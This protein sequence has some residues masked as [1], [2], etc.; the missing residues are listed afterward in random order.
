MN[1]KT[2]LGTELKYKVTMTA[3]GFDMDTDDWEVTIVRGATKRTFTKSECVQGQDGWF[4]CFDTKDFGA[5]NYYAIMTAFVPDADFDDG[6]R[7]EVKKFELLSVE[8]V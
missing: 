5:G 6:Y 1:D 8:S 7:K 2:Y 3:T 4:V